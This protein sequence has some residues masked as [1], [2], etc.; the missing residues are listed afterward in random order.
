[1]D[2]NAEIQEKNQQKV[3][4]LCGI[5][6]MQIRPL[7]EGNNFSEQKNTNIKEESVEGKECKTQS[8]RYN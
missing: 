3:L 6:Q 7:Y 4:Y 5:L 1:M 2:K 8:L